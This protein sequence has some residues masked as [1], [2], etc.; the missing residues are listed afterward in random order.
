MP[1]A[2]RFLAIALFY[3]QLASSG[4]CARKSAG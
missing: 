3:K 4:L 2:P 1:F